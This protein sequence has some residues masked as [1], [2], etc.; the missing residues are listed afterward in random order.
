M[1]WRKS[2]TNERRE[3]IER[4]Y[5]AIVAQARN[6]VFYASMGAPDTLEGR[7][8]LV[9]LHVFLVSR[10]LGDVGGQGPAAAQELLDRFFEDMDGNLREIGIGDLSVPKKMRAMGEAYLG[11]AAAYDG[12]LKSGDMSALEAALAKNIYGGASEKNSANIAA[13]ARY[14]REAASAFQRVEVER[15]IEAQIP[16][17]NPIGAGADAS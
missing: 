12:A 1:F 6:P 3:T 5:G 10:R 9:L 11:R 7:F 4:L 8:D 16:F 13:L 14:V 2:P 17:P 15:L